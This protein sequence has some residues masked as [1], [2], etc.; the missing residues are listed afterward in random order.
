MAQT[1]RQA[2]KAARQRER[3]IRQ[4]SQQVIDA[5]VKKKKKKDDIPE[6][7]YAAQMADAANVVEF[8]N[9]KTYFYTDIGVVKAVDGVSFGVPMGK[10]IGLVGESGCGKSVT[11]L[12]LMR[13]LQEPVGQIAGG[14]IRYND[15]KQAVDIAKLPEAKMRGIRG[16][17]ISMIFQEP[18]TSL[19]PVFTIGSQI[20]EA[21][22]LHNP[23]MS[24]DE[25]YKRAVE[26]IDMVGISRAEGIYRAY[27]H[28]LSGGMRQRIMIAM[29][30]SCD[31]RLI[32]ADEP[33]TAL[34]VTIQ[35]QILDLLRNLK[36]KINA[37]IMLITHDLGVVAEMAD[38][39]VVMY[40]GRIIEQ[41]PVREVF[42]NP[43]HPYTIGLLESKPV[44]NRAVERLYSIP[45]QVPNPINMPACCYFKDRCDRCVAA[46]DGA[47][48]A[49]RDVTGG[50]Q[51]SC[52]LYGEGEGA[53]E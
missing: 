36:D 25:V 6:S 21:I 8:D 50:H 34:D 1:I 4:A 30:L 35:A 40:A 22:K 16:N 48:P 52:Y 20:D 42:H 28:E 15:G 9:L 19:N 27:P 47:Y 33:T 7:A 13:L 17:E 23:N 10:T 31:P 18:M 43:R 29:A 2:K 49:M 11:S 24:D 5:F 37:S 3:E 53:H 26:L 41:G 32:I 38:I 51:V 12:S 14:Q 46:C 39:V 45:G 44:L